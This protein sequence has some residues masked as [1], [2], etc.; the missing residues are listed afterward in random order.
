MD[1]LLGLLCPQ[2]GEILVDG[3]DIQENI[4]GWQRC[5]G[6][7]PQAVFFAMTRLPRMLPFG[8]SQNEIDEDRVHCVL[9][10][11]NLTDLVAENRLGIH[12][13]LGEN[14]IKLSGGQRQ[15]VGI[16][17]LFIGILSC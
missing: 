7:V 8:I 1:L 16:A 5:I 9:E 11:A 6:Y 14:G 2:K 3:R 17:V 15:R 13:P 10:E 4:V 12:M